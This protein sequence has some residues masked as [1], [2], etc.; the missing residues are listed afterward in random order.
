MDILLAIF[1]N[2]I[3]PKTARQK[4]VQDRFMTTSHLQSN[5]QLQMAADFV[6]LTNTNIFLTG[7]AGT[8]KTTF[9]RQLRQLT[10][11]RLVVVAP[12]GV[13]AINAG[14]VTIHSFFQL[15]FGPQL[16]ESAKRV[17]DGENSFD[18][19]RAAQFQRYT[20]EKIRLIKSIDLLVI[21]EISM[22]RADLL[23]AI[24]AVLRRFRHRNKAF[25]GVQL[26]MIGDM[27]Q[28][29]PI[30][31]EEEWNLLKPY[32]PTVYFFNSLALQKAGYI[33]I[34]LT[35]V[36][37]QQDQH[38]I[39]L[40][41]KIR[42]NK[43]DQETIGALNERYL[44]EKAA[45][46]PPGYITL[47]TH[48]HQAD[49]IN[50]HHLEQI[51]K[52]LLQYEATVRDDF[53]EYMFPAEQKLSLKIGA[54]VMFIKNDPSPEKLFF[55][56]K[57]GQLVG[58]ED[59]KLVV[60]CQDEVIEV[61]QLTWNNYRYKL[62]EET[63][64]VDENIIGSF[65]QYPLKLA[66]AITIH[67]SQG[68]TFDRMI[69]DANAAFAHGQVY[70]A[71]SRC[72]SLE[73]IILS[74]PLKSEAIK[75]DSN[76]A[77]FNQKS[78]ELSPD[79]KKLLEARQLYEQSL[80]HEVFG[81]DGFSRIL[82]SI[83]YVVREN[84]GSFDADQ[85]QQ[86]KTM[87]QKL[88]DELIAIAE[89]FMKQVVHLQKPD[90][91]LSDND[92][93][94]DRLKRASEFFGPKVEEILQPDILQF[95][96]DNKQ[97]R[98]RIK[99]QLEQF[100][101]IYKLKLAEIEHFTRGFDAKKLLEERV[102]TGSVPTKRKALPKKEIVDG[103]ENGKVLKALVQWRNELAKAEG[104]PYH[105]IMPR[106][107]IL[108]MSSI[109]PR[110][111]KE[112]ETIKGL[113]K[114]RISKYGD[115]LIA[116]ITAALEQKEEEDKPDGEKLKKETKEIKKS[117]LEL[118]LDML[119]EG[120]SAKSIAAQRGLAVSTIESHLAELIL[121]G[122]LSADEVVEKTK[123]AV[124]TTYFLDT[125]DPRLGPAKEVLGDEY[126]YAELRYVLNELKREGKMQQ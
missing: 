85:V 82:K 106:K 13:A 105:M 103:N 66:W 39:T 64:Q 121:R 30:A 119:R 102:K 23:D 59:E 24:D 91:T 88:D 15:P 81:F 3:S 71:L 32:Y 112:L 62:N 99:D 76:I 44:P 38:F 54:Q 77:G 47:T 4:T 55:N 115:V 113:G 109:L 37:R 14:G 95:E 100:D 114:R 20:R 12:T 19:S 63:Q 10:W 45:A 68:L 11:K 33:C 61:E 123:L 117:S 107:T 101:E 43:A 89:K 75:M 108:T 34:E 26:L 67:K 28:L 27:Q 5:A 69:I 80:V 65:T 86:L 125:E 17:A 16:P 96:T 50:Q 94:L 41:N 57:I 35:Q 120:L 73:G 122:D 31:K 111:T 6:Q 93:L 48:N 29:A 25:G 2:F 124:I 87:R 42:D 83:E 18:K 36:F 84:E 72:T 104:L 74:T 97:L 118:T 70:V 126:S 79:R 21:D 8:G 7:K 92:V 78:K 22:V 116:I 40:L 53:P 51:K 60:K 90:L 46:Q 52:P 110:S 1:R 98:K 9:L 56:G 58:V 49:R